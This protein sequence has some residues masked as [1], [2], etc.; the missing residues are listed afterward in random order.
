MSSIRDVAERA[1]VSVATVSRALRGLP[2]VSA[3]TRDRVR[4]AALDLGYVPSAPAAGLASGRTMSV[5]IVVP[6]A[7]RWFFTGVQNS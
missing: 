7:T 3:A 2:R 5:G 4:L 6:Y 1:G